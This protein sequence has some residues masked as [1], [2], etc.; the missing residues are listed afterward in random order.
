[1]LFQRESVSE[2]WD[3]LLPLAGQHH[4]E[5]QI[6]WPFKA[7]RGP[8]DA[9][10]KAGLL[11]VYTMRDNAGFLKGY[12]VFTVMQHPHY[13]CRI[14]YQDTIYVE[15]KSRGFWSGRFLIWVDYEL[16]RM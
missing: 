9:M 15:P 11:A 14:G 7:D 10:E 1:M 13:E 2:V 6:H 4:A 16:T 3:E 5:N 12:Q 8:Y